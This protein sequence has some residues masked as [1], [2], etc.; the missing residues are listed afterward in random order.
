ML[1]AIRSSGFNAAEFDPPTDSEF[2]TSLR[3][4]PSGSTF[5]IGPIDPFGTRPV[6]RQVGDDPAKA[7]DRR[8]WS[9]EF[10]EWLED[11]ERYSS[12][13]DLW[14]EL[15]R[16]Q[17]AMGGGVP[18]SPEEDTPFTPVEQAEIAKG[19]R[20]VAAYAADTGDFDADQI[21]VL[22][23]KIDYLIETAKSSR[24]AAW[25]EQLIG[26]FVS[27]TMGNMLPEGATIDVLKTAV[28]ALGHLFGHPQLG[29]PR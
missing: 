7:R 5:M 25:R 21:R 26:A 13:P 10:V 24:R 17:E 6:M 20:E 22:N 12:T 11:I 23:A 9:L 18:L 19:L 27:A 4:K 16:E 29:L 1:T 3:H 15:A 8:T 2:G 28:A 14:A